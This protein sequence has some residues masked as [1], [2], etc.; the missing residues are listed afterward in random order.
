MFGDDDIGK[1]ILVV[2]RSIIY[3]DEC[4]KD[5]S[6]SEDETP[7]QPIQLKAF[8]E[9]YNEAESLVK[10]LTIFFF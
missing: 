10:W 4:W 7:H 2:N 6:D 3:S 9:G 5:N 1:L 8:P